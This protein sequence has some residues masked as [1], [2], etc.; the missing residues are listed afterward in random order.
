MFTNAG[1][2]S[3]G[4]QAERAAE[5]YLSKQGLRL[6]ARNYR[7][8]QGEI[9]L[10]MLD[11]DILVFIEVRYRNNA[12]HGSPLESVTASKQKKLVIAAKHY[13]SENKLS[14]N[15]QTRFDV[16][17]I[18]SSEYQWVQSAFSAG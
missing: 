3:K 2:S 8:K 10:I 5:R 15:T 4:N 14:G 11:G 12:N 9:D 18:C 1:G 17:G 13:L 7:C 6:V 16:L